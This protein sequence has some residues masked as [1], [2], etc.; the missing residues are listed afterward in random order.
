MVLIGWD[1][2]F[3]SNG[4]II[5]EGISFVNAKPREIEI[6]NQAIKQIPSLSSI[7]PG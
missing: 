7:P 2:A 5:R 4:S 1:L 6:C 3:M